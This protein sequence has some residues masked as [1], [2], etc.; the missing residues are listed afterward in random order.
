MYC[1]ITIDFAEFKFFFDL[2]GLDAM[3]YVF[4]EDK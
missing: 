4:M 3:K 1:N 2:S